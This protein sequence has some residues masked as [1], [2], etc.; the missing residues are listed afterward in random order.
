MKS[1]T[2]ALHSQQLIQFNRFDNV[3]DIVGLKSNQRL[4]IELPVHKWIL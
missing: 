3:A 4:L 1:M 2:K